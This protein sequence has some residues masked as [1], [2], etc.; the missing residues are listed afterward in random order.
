MWATNF[1]TNTHMTHMKSPRSTIKPSEW[2]HYVEWQTKQIGGLADDGRWVL[3]GSGITVHLNKPEC[4]YDVE[5]NEFSIGVKHADDVVKPV[6]EAERQ[7]FERMM[8]REINRRRRSV[9]PTMIEVFTDMGYTPN[10]FVGIDKPMFKTLLA[11]L[12]SEAER[13]ETG[14]YLHVTRKSDLDENKEKHDWQVVF[15]GLVKY[16]DL[17]DPVI[18]KRFGERYGSTGLCKVKV[19]KF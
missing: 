14:G 16:I 1:S 6:N 9:V 4:S 3:P 19:C 8:T 10:A 7:M 15:R 13:H 2:A 17:N 11:T 12:K 5:F 18:R